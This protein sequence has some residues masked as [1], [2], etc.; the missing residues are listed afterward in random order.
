MYLFFAE[1]RD[2]GMRRLGD[3]S[4]LM[5]KDLKTGADTS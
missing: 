5:I 2:P 1:K 3:L 4:G